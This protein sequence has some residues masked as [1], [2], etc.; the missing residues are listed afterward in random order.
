MAGG[1]PIIILNIKKLLIF[2]KKGK[3]IGSAIKQC[4][5]QVLFSIAA[6]YAGISL[7]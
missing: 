4:S 3:G 1:D 2:I 5:P 7:M 6:P